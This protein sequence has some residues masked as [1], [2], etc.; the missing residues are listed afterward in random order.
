MSALQMKSC[1]KRL[2]GLVILCLMIHFDLVKQMPEHLTDESFRMVWSWADTPILCVCF[3]DAKSNT[4]AYGMQNM[5]FFN[6]NTI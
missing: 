5:H 4:W 6:N 1:L 3:T 2:F